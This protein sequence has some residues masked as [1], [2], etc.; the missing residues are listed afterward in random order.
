MGVSSLG[1]DFYE[2]ADATT[3]FGGIGNDRNVE[4]AA[5]AGLALAVNVHTSEIFT[6]LERIGWYL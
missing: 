2:R 1:N 5:M 3:I 6:V 4:Y